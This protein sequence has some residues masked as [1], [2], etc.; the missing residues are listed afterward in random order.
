MEYQKVFDKM[1]NSLISYLLITHF[2]PKLEIVV[3]SDASEDGIG[4]AILQ[5]FIGN[6]KQV[7]HASR[8]LLM[9]EKNYIE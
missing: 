1:K 9:A 4:A 3:V 8:T 7:A 2:D 6:T 5:K